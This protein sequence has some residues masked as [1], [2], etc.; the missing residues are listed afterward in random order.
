MRNN[1]LFWKRYI[2]VFVISSPLS[3]IFPITNSILTDIQFTIEAMI[4]DKIL[5][6]DTLVHVQN[7]IFCVNPSGLEE[8]VSKVPDER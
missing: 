6:L 2:E 4:D 3:N 5:F 1:I 8:F 7:I